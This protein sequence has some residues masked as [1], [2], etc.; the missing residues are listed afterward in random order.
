ME[1]LVIVMQM[2]IASGIIRVHPGGVRRQDVG[3]ILIQEI[4]LVPQ[5]VFG[6]LHGAIAMKKAVGAM[7][8]KLI[9]GQIVA[10]GNKVA[11]GAMRKDVG[12]WPMNLVV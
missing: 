9:V 4:V 8:T 5:D 1:I 10:S 11:A 3:I 7:I 6:T 12:I 2:I